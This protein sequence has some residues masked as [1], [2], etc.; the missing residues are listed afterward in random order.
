MSGPVAQVRGVRKMRSP[1]A[2]RARNVNKNK[3]VVDTLNRYFPQDRATFGK[4]ESDS[5]DTVDC[6]GVFTMRQLVVDTLNRC[7]PGRTAPASARVSILSTV[8]DCN[9]ARAF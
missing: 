7:F 8:R 4:G 9:A 1:K 2:A 3:L 6:S 5:R